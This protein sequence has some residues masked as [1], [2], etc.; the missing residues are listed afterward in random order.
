MPIAV[1]WRW[2]L[3]LQAVNCWAVSIAG[4]RAPRTLALGR[5]DDDDAGHRQRLEQR[6]G[7]MQDQLER[8]RVG[9]SDLDGNR[10]LLLNAR[11]EDGG[12]VLGQ[13]ALSSRAAW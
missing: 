10:L 8:R 3:A 4:Y 9:L 13:A 12:S 6:R 7:D 5:E 11:R 2:N 1:W